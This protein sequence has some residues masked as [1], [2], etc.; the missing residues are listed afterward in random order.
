MSAK[1][2]TPLG[3]SSDIVVRLCE[4]FPK[5]KNSILF[6]DSLFTSFGLFCNLKSDEI[7][8]CGT[9]ESFNVKQ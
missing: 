2:P 6:T 1:Q 8:A 5:Q 4:N 3:I 7:L 9:V